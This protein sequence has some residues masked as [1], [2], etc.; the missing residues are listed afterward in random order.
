M[1]PIARG[2]TGTRF[3]NHGDVR[4]E[5]NSTLDEI[6]DANM[7]LAE[8]TQTYRQERRQAQWLVA[9]C[10][11]SA[12]VVAVL[13]GIDVSGVAG[14]ITLALGLASGMLGFF[15]Y[16]RFH[17]WYARRNCSRMVREL[18]RG[19]EPVGCTFEV[20][21]DSL[22]SRVKDIETSFPWSSLTRVNE[23]SDSIELWFNPGLAVVRNRA[24]QSQDERRVFLDRTRSLMP[25]GSS[26]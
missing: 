24:F 2:G 1:H 9:V 8:R 7:R 25:I 3:E 6:V 10:Y 4:L 19:L 15:V 11:A 21:Q 17:D 5:F 26:S 22:W 23:A 16:G 14:A 13:R 12:S 18:Y 20:R